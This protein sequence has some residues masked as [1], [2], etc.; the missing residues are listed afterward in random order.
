LFLQ[1]IVESFNRPRSER[2]NAEDPF[3]LLLSAKA[4]GV[5]LNLIGGNRLVLFDL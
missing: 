5:G 4:G 2:R 1:G 3:L